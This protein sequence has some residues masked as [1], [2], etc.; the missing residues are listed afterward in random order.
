MYTNLKR[1]VN[2]CLFAFMLL[3][4]FTASV[5]AE[6]EPNNTIT[7]AQP[8]AV[9]SNE[10]GSLSK[11][12]PFDL[13]DVYKVNIAEHGYFS[14]G[15]VPEPEVDVRAELIDRDGFTVLSGGNAGGLG[16][17]E[18]VIFSNLKKGEY[19]CVVHLVDG[20]GG[21]EARFRY[22]QVESVDVEPNDVPLQAISMGADDDVAGNLGFHGNRET[23]KVDFYQIQT[24]DDGEIELTAAPDAS[25]DLS[26][27]LLD[28]NGVHVILEDTNSGA[29]QSEAVTVSNLAAGTYFVMVYNVGGY[30]AYSLSSNFTADPMPNDAEPNDTFSQA[31]SFPTAVQSGDFLSTSMSGHTGYFGNQ[32]RDDRDC[33]MFQVP[34]YSRVEFEYSQDY[35]SPELGYGIYGPQKRYLT[36]SGSTKFNAG[37]FEAGTYYLNLYR[38]NNHGAY[39][40]NIR[41]YPENQPEPFSASAGTY[42]LGQTLSGVP[43]N[44]DSPASYYWFDLAQDSS[45][46]FK[47]SSVDTLY[48]TTRI[49]GPK[50]LNSMGNLGAYYTNDAKELTIPHMLAGR[51]L[52][53]ITRDNGQGNVTFESTVTPSLYHDAEP[54]D[55]W[56]EAVDVLPPDTLIQGHL[57]HTNSR[58][59]DT[60]DTYRIDIPSD[61]AIKID[62]HGESTLYFNVELAEYHGSTWKRVLREGLYYTDET[63]VKTVSSPNLVA[64]RYI[65]QVQRENGYGDYELDLSFTPNQTGDYEY[66][67]HPYQAI[68][69]Q[70]EEGVT[71]HLGYTGGF[72]TDT[73]DWYKIVTQSDGTLEVY[74]QG[75]D[76]L[77]YEVNLFRNDAQS[78]F[79]SG[80]SYYTKNPVRL[81][82][83]QVKAGV[84]YIRVLRQNGYGVYHLFATFTPNPTPDVDLNN[85]ATMAQPL[86]LNQVMQGS[87]G[88]NNRTTIDTIDWYQFTITNQASYKLT[89]QTETALYSTIRIF[90]A[91]SLNRLSSDGVYYHSNL[92]SRDITLQPGTYYVYCLRENGAGSYTLSVGDESAAPTGVLTGT[93]FDKNQL[94][95]FEV[96]VAAYGQSVKTDFGGVYTFANLPPGRY[97]AS[98]GKGAK[99]YQQQN[100]FVITAGQTTTMDVVLKEAN[101]NPPADVMHY[102]GFAGNG[103]LHLFWD[104]TVSPD[105]ADGGGYNLYIN[106]DKFDLGTALFFRQHEFSNGVPYELRLTVYDKFDNESTGKTLYLTPNSDGPDQPTPTPVPPTATPAP[107]Q[108]TP[109]PGVVVPTATP[110]PPAGQPTPTPTIPVVAP[111]ATPIVPQVLEPDYVFEFDGADLDGCGWGEI[112]QSPPGQTQ[113]IDFI[114]SFI[115]NSADGKG[116]A[117]TV[118][119]YDAAGGEKLNYV[120]L[121]GASAV[122]TTGK[123]VYMRMTARASDPNVAVFIAAMKADF[124]TFDVEGSLVVTNP[125]SAK[126]FTDTPMYVTCLFPADP[127]RLNLQTGKLETPVTPVTPIIQVAASA[128]ATGPV[129]VWVDKLEVFLLD[130]A[131]NYPASL[132]DLS[133]K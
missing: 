38:R 126:A 81:K 27:H 44:A 41:F 120:F 26:L 94:E 51:Y 25:L 37:P 72:N 14:F 102:Y 74:A 33:Y 64:G 122:K 127:K 92:F 21:Y 5:N 48:V 71:G 123:H 69:L 42:T 24:T 49:Y 1:S 23:D 82:N 53:A 9:P 89:Y 109:T 61:G 108:P 68:T 111:T 110:T 34:Q 112:V 104:P 20:V 30:G 19:Y 17:T 43:I 13:T 65:I 8:V 56:N 39:T 7:T 80:G 131:L 97:I 76:T 77:Y 78:R 91:S 93:V 85:F 114:R 98:I 128:A 4:L 52:L 117:L 29:G 95:I 116:L 113:L 28:T 103:T 100:E 58:W 88:F 105:V 62:F 60:T 45:V 16:V 115:P 84:N 55:V 86:A 129:I 22:S 130:P 66:N 87:L 125:A 133:I 47:M 121:Y 79:E 67:N 83:V 132:F 31:A 106:G 6:I 18:G 90:D 57:G 107:G 2:F 124:A 35:G 101:L 32:Y 36:G 99:Y 96:D 119:P 50:G 70:S 63:V 73:A 12:S 75:E 59:T 11:A 118:F 40:V 15:I 46:W 3:C 10:T 54:N